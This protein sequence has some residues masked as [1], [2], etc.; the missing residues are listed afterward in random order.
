MCAQHMADKVKGCDQ[1]EQSHY[2]CIL[3]KFDDGSSDEH[4]IRTLFLTYDAKTINPRVI[5]YLQRD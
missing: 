5:C 4:S 1:I 3:T 2:E